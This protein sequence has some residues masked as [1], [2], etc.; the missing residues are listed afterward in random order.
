MSMIST[1]F[2]WVQWGVFLTF[3]LIHFLLGV[4]RG[5]LKTSYY[6]W[7]SVMITLLSLIA[8]SFMSIQWAIDVPGILSTAENLFN[9]QLPEDI[10]LI[11]VDP[12]MQ[13]IIG[14]VL[15]II[16]KLLMFIIV[17][18][19]IKFLLTRTVFKLFWKHMIEHTKEDDVTT[20]TR[21][22]SRFFGG[23]LGSIRGFVTAYFILIPLFFM[24]SAVN[25]I[26]GSSDSTSIKAKLSD[27]PQSENNSTLDLILDEVAKT[28]DQSISRYFNRFT[29]N[30]K[31][32]EDMV[33]SSIMT[34]EIKNT[35]DEVINF[36][37]SK[38]IKIIGGIFTQLVEDGYLKND[39]DIN[40]ITHETHYEGIDYMLEQVG[41]SNLLPAFFP[42]VI[43]ILDNHPGVL[44]TLGYK[45][46]ENTFTQNAYNNLKKIDWQLE[47]KQLSNVISDILTIDDLQILLS[48]FE[49]PSVLLTLPNDKLRQFSNVIKS[50]S[51]LQILEATP[52]GIEYFLS[53][54]ST[55]EIV[56]WH[57]D[58]YAYMHDRFAFLYEAGFVAEELD[59][60]A[61]L[62]QT[63]FDEKYA[64]LD[65]EE[66]FG[67]SGQFDLSLY[68]E[69]STSEF[70]SDVLGSLVEIETLLRVIPFAV[71]VA[72]Y[73]SD[74]ATIESIA[75]E[76][77]A[78]IADERFVVED[79]IGHIDS[80]Y[81][82]LVQMGLETLFED[83]V[84]MID[85]LDAILLREDNFNHTK[86]IVKIL[87]EDSFVINET[88]SIAAEPVINQMVEDEEIK[89]LAKEILLH[90]EFEYGK[91][92]IS[93]LNITEHVYSFTTIGQVLT[94]VSNEDY[95]AILN[96]LAGMNQAQFESLKAD[97]F[98]LQTLNFGN[99]AILNY[100]QT[101]INSELL[102]VPENMTYEDFK[103]D[104][105]MILDVA[106]LAANQIH[107]HEIT[108]ENLRDTDL[109]DI[110]PF[111]QLQQILTFNKEKHDQSII[112][113]SIVNYISTAN[114]NLGQLGTFSMPKELLE[115][116][117]NSDL[118]IDE[119]NYI[120]FGALDLLQ[121]VQTLN[122]DIK[123]SMNELTNLNGL[124]DIPASVIT[125][126]NDEA[127]IDR[128]FTN[129]LK[130]SI[131]R[132]NGVEVTKNVV[133]TNLD[134]I[135]L[136]LSSFDY[137]SEAMNEANLI[138][139]LKITLNLADQ[140]LVDPSMDL[141][142]NFKAINLAHG[143]NIF[144]NL[145]NH[146]INRI[147]TH[148]IINDSFRHLVLN[149]SVQSLA[150]NF[151]NDLNIADLPQIDSGIFE[152]NVALDS[153]GALKEETLT[154]I[155][156]F[157]RKLKVPTNIDQLNQQQLIEVLVDK[158]RPSLIDDL[159][160]I[161]LIH[162]VS[163]NIIK[164]EA[165]EIVGEKYFNQLMT[166]LNQQGFKISLDY[167]TYYNDLMRVLLDTNNLIS[168]EEIKS[169]VSSFIAFENTS[170]TTEDLST[171]N[172][173]RM[174]E[175][176]LT[177]IYNN[178]NTVEYISETKLIR[179]LLQTILNDDN[180]LSSVANMANPY[181]VFNGEPI[182]TLQGSDL[183]LDP[184]L[185]SANGMYQEDVYQLIEAILMQDLDVINQG[186][187]T[188]QNLIDLTKVDATSHKDRLSYIYDS[189]VIESILK[190]I[191]ESDKVKDSIVQI[192]NEQLT[193]FI[194]PMSIDFTPYVREDFNL[195]FELINYEAA[196]QM[197]HTVESLNINSFND[198][199]QI[200]S[201]Q[202]I[203]DILNLE[204]TRKSIDNISEIPIVYEIY[205]TLMSSEKLSEFV[206]NVVNYYAIDTY[207][208][209]IS[210]V[211]VTTFTIDPIYDT[212]KDLADLMV[213]L[214]GV[215]VDFNSVFTS[216]HFIDDLLVEVYI[217]GQKKNSIMNLL[218][219]R[220]I[221]HHLD[222][223]LQSHLIKE[224]LANTLNNFFD[225]NN[226]DIH[227]T[228]DEIHIPT[229][230]LNKEGRI[231]KQEFVTLV[232]S[233][234]TLN[235]S[236]YNELTRLTNITS[237]KDTIPIAFYE[238]LLESKLV[239]H[240]M[241]EL[242]TNST[243]R[244]LLADQL[245]NVL[246]NFNVNI[247][248]S[249]NNF[250][251]PNHLLDNAGKIKVEDILTVIEGLYMTQQATF[252][253]N[254]KAPKDI[255]RI[256]P[257]DALDHI[258]SSKLANYALTQLLQGSTVR[259][260]MASIA[261]NQVRRLSGQKVHVAYQADDFLLP[262]TLLSE[263]GYIKQSDI[264]VIVS[265]FY[266][267][268][269]DHFNQIKM[270]NP[271]QIEDVVP[272]DV[273]QSL[274][275]D[276]ELIHYIMDSFLR[277]PNTRIALSNVF[278]EFTKN[279]D[280][281]ITLTP[282][283]FVLPDMAL[284]NDMIM[285]SD[286]VDFVA[287]FYNLGI[288]HFANI[289]VSGPKQIE[290]IMS[291]GQFEQLLDINLV[292]GVVNEIATSSVL[293]Q[294]IAHTLNTYLPQFNL[295]T[296]DNSI[297][298]LPKTVLVDGQISKAELS[299]LVE[300]FYDLNVDNF[301]ELSRLNQVSNIKSIFTKDYFTKILESELIYYVMGYLPQHER[302][303]N[304][305]ANY[306]NSNL[307]RQLGMAMNLN[308]D[309]FLLDNY[310][311]LISSG[312]YQGYIK[313]DELQALY[314]GFLVFDHAEIKGSLYTII[315]QSIEELIR[316]IDEDHVVLDKLLES[317][318]LLN[319]INRMINLEQK[320]HLEKTILDLM[321]NTVSSAGIGQVEFLASD[322]IFNYHASAFDQDNNISKEEIR[323]TVF[324]LSAI[325]FNED[326][327]VK[328]LTSLVGRNLDE[329]GVDDF[330]RF[331]QSMVMQSI[332]SNMLL[333]DRYV[334]KFVQQL[335]RR[336]SILEFTTEL[337]AI[338][339]SIVEEGIIDEQEMKLLLNT[340]NVLGIEGIDVTVIGLD[341]F[342]SLDGRNDDGT[343]DDL[344]RFL[345]SFIMHTYVDRFIK[346]D[347]LNDVLVTQVNQ[348]MDSNV[349]AVDSS[350]NDGMLDDQGMF[351]KS[352]FRGLIQS[353][354]LLG[355]TSHNDLGDLT[356]SDILALNNAA[357]DLDKFL[358]SNYLRTMIGRM[359]GSR[360]IKEKISTNAGFNQ[361][362]FSLNAVGRDAYNEMSK[363]EVKSVLIALDTL[364]IEDFDA[365]TISNETLIGLSTDELNTVL[366]SNYFYQMIDL[367]LRAELQEQ[368]VPSSLVAGDL[369]Y[370][371]YIKQQE[372][373]GLVE[374][375]R[376]LNI[377]NAGSLDSNAITIADLELLLA[378]DAQILR[379][380]MSDAI[381]KQI[382][383]PE[384]SYEAY[385]IITDA[386]FYHLLAGLRIL[387]QNDD[388][389]TIGSINMQDTTVTT[390][391]F[392]NLL[393]IGTDT[394]PINGSH[395]ITR[396]LSEAVIDA[397]DERLDPLA[398]SSEFDIYRTELYFLKDA[399]FE[400][401]IYEI[402]GT[403]NIADVSTL[404]V[405]TIHNYN[406][407]IINKLISD[408][409]K[410]NIEDIPMNAYELEDSTNKIIYEEVGNL[411]DVMIY[412]DIEIS[413]I[414]AFDFNTLDAYTIEEVKAYDSIIVNHMI[415]NQ[416]KDNV[417]DIPNEAY[418]MSDPS[419][420]ILDIELDRLID[421]LKLLNADLSQLDN[422]SLNTIDGALIK[423]IYEVA[424]IIINHKISLEIVDALDDIPLAAFKDDDPTKDL[425][426]V[427]VM[428]LIDVL[429]YLDVEISQLD[430]LGIESLDGHKL[431][432][433]QTIGALSIQRLI[434][435]EMKVN[436]SD[437]PQAAYVNNDPNE[438]IKPE[439]INKLIDV[440]IL[441]D[442]PIEN[443]D[444]LD[445]KTLTFDL[446]NDVN[447]VNSR[448]MDRM[449]SNAL[450]DEPAIMT[451]NALNSEGDVSKEELTKF[452]D[453]LNLIDGVNNVT[454]FIDYLNN[455]T[456]LDLPT[457]QVLATSDSIILK[458]TVEQKII[459]LTM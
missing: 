166:S 292:Y 93:I 312:D 103:T 272:L 251:I 140:L 347:A 167:K 424:S 185:F 59:N 266:N 267:L 174:S 157:A 416:V 223:L 138:E 198:L 315:N 116:P 78:M 108:T 302:V 330:D 197:I 80:V 23:F 434:S 69:E 182:V 21:K 43:D 256:L 334:S 79:E 10:R 188:L 363:D 379:R 247:N 35:N 339:D 386:E 358:T 308:K 242:L 74:D 345:E 414:D 236:N 351:S 427:E 232:S 219:S 164:H 356:I 299:T 32:F 428:K 290:K 99:K 44:N 318:I 311:V 450:I 165:V 389:Q 9:F 378:I 123:F 421:V 111:N 37:L 454:E 92:L 199:A 203:R 7:T 109:V 263:E 443:L 458:D 229:S 218:D 423:D 94:H 417:E 246:G 287:L 271:G 269:I 49:D 320:P 288:D 296:I 217:D 369:T 158:L 222:N 349:Q 213:A 281:G 431:K 429:I 39:F 279:L 371:G 306:A 453:A 231:E 70:V 391:M 455:L 286:I 338:P 18:P 151:I 238:K 445:T 139:L 146:L 344:D 205:H 301:N 86:L 412:L 255:E 283:H 200:N 153:Q 179:V 446:V 396:L 277:N 128:G 62:I 408:E 171:N 402:T 332:L 195:N 34:V 155:L 175:E 207:N 337:L 104:V 362:D 66:L 159:F 50:L 425:T 394:D 117:F 298:K 444:N 51:A 122:L 436:L 190:G 129:L 235:I 225:Q 14:G 426:D 398:Y 113:N 19:S 265:N 432:D 16:F 274:M 48:Y 329:Q 275:Y 409:V 359:L 107:T 341:L 31:T 41:G 227:L 6:F 377:T 243:S 27:A 400:L 381:A 395:L 370:D 204:T 376:I 150:Y 180:L 130:S 84:E 173:N 295:P 365:V 440:L 131:L 353:L 451:D 154:Q 270:N 114:F 3:I 333:N 28:N 186:A 26:S 82:I 105:T 415:S 387:T 405:R 209:P 368:V 152:L 76:I 46:S 331:Y 90:D 172:F 435:N 126:L 439:E 137:Q 192:V 244:Q 352:E 221:Y 307:S 88:L 442:E 63:V 383:V 261:N 328:G 248:L 249:P 342:I 38:E 47:T 97:I 392:V 73:T 127:V 335:N 254:I 234:A 294:A 322:R 30:G 212:H 278:N 291:I 323:R 177:P 457:L 214:L 115:E 375:L 360:T 133:A 61:N 433:I 65:Y 206:A 5:I 83:D 56:T 324:G 268:G 91:E 29:I 119:I 447:Q 257:L 189:R 280:L 169:Y 118:W 406:S 367:T 385:E 303:R 388:T 12:N 71:D 327:S 456:I 310:E 25:G 237:I 147:G 430:S 264:Q 181:L 422:L 226:I 162:E 401:E 448:I 240:T 228:T 233:V 77:V 134:N 319:I 210:P 364:G 45:P 374:A 156:L 449:I 245:S 67:L 452:I 13:L 145:D 193:K 293:P 366:A 57:E 354:K 100:V 418:E 441:I 241:S 160:D 305:L 4:K 106:Y 15:D 17:Y 183:K 98:K 413:N 96:D 170:I 211:N 239:H 297:I 420:A 343:Q 81:Q 141:D 390:V 142:Y 316:P 55:L 373:H 102:Q 60:L 11:I 8:I 125:K 176:L 357:N 148:P 372:I 259:E 321:S 101:T 407:I 258:L 87:F 40:N 54:S 110:L 384:L 202:S 89:Q 194:G 262:E 201:L 380:I 350:V 68:L 393:N 397:F 161:K 72:V 230:A 419:K 309:D 64:D 300:I 282:N 276:T 135:E 168:N 121:E 411:I 289:P 253:L 304:T 75:S 382:N 336:Q 58:P 53:D 224:G 459:D 163:S 325:D 208:L 220:L 149:E 285:K 355:V 215:N 120:L 24:L 52:L 20:K 85:A 22:M 314:E 410:D 361:K 124:E 178:K 1:A 196:K 191:I 187:F 250:M 95:I 136:P 2:I 399:L 143:I 346:S 313:K 273:V 260:A 437:I 112:L 33:M 326:L 252:T 340:L 36:D 144:N 42:T 404:K 348:L 132:H 216:P 403:L 184:T 317:N 284:E 438:D